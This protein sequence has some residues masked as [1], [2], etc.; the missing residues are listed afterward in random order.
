MRANGCFL[1]SVRKM[2]LASRGKRLSARFRYP[3]EFLRRDPGAASSSDSPSGAQPRQTV[4][5]AHAAPFW[6]SLAVRVSAAPVLAASFDSA[7][8]RRRNRHHAPLVRHGV[9][10]FPPH[11]GNSGTRL[12]KPCGWFK[13]AIDLDQVKVPLPERRPEGLPEGIWLRRG[14]RQV[15][16]AVSGERPLKRAALAVEVRMKNRGFSLA[17]TDQAE[18][19]GRVNAGIHRCLLD[20][21]RRGGRSQARGSDPDAVVNTGWCLRARKPLARRIG[22]GVRGGSG[23]YRVVASRTGAPAA[24]SERDQGTLGDM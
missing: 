19:W 23:M 11:Q 24:A 15:R 10:P 21:C 4:A 16:A 20:R 5:A 2:I 14:A 12:P 6:V 18:R 7:A 13:R 3:V 1:N 22:H 17:G 8:R 9:V